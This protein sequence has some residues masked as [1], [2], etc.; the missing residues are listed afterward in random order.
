MIKVK[1]L[2]AGLFALA[3]IPTSQATTAGEIQIPFSL[4]KG[5]LLY[6]KYCSACHGV[7]LDGSEQ[8]PPLI[9]PFYKPPHHD[10]RSFYRAALEG[11]GQHHWEFGDMPAV[12]GMTAGKMDSLL[13]Y[14]R[15]YQQQKGLY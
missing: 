5:Q 9:H 13:P 4:G 2:L 12:E 7:Q 6:E 15:Y 1:I 11:V 8:G 14:I 3:A 10:D